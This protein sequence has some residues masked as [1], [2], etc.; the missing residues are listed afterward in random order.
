MKLTH[1]K[2]YEPEKAQSKQHKDKTIRSRLLSKEIFGG[3]KLG[4]TENLR[5]VDSI[6]V[7]PNKSSQKR[8]KSSFVPKM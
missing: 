1:T 2:F 8:M 6:T 4:G 7:H 3:T 5:T